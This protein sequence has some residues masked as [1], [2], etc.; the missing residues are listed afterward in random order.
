MVASS[1][2]VCGTCQSDYLAIGAN[3]RFGG[4]G[5]IGFL[6]FGQF[7][8]E[9]RTNRL[10]NQMR[11]AEL[12]LAEEDLVSGV[13]IRRADAGKEFPSTSSA[14]IFPRPTPPHQNTQP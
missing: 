4:R 3:D 10:A 1:W 13:T 2:I 9:E 11:P 14:S 12:V 8:L 5:R 6:Q 7:R